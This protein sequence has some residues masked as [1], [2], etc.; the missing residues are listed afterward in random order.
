MEVGI[1][2]P[3]TGDERCVKMT[4]NSRQTSCS[5]KTRKHS[6]LAP[7]SKKISTAW[8]RKLHDAIHKRLWPR[9]KNW[10]KT[11]MK[12]PQ[13]LGLGTT[14]VGEKGTSCS[15]IMNGIHHSIRSIK[16]GKPKG[17]HINCA[18]TNCKHT[19]THKNTRTSAY[20][21]CLCSCK[22]EERI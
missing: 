15:R 4:A 20:W 19:Q 14:S 13:Y 17:S 21:S 11:T 12:L 10:E 18:K 5:S 2:D 1:S 6:L 22:H 3:L 7:K 8:T 16:C 9:L